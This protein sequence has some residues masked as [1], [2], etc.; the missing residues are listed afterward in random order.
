MLID[1]RSCSVI[2]REVSTCSRW[3]QIERPMSGQCAE[4]E[5][6][7]TLSPEWD[8]FVKNHTPR[9]DSGNPGEEGPK[10][11]KSQWRWKTP[12]KHDL[13]ITRPMKDMKPQRL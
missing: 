5:R 9:W 2:I 7:Y 4:S 13:N 11:F 10:G 6:S 12:R 1:H 8:V 3:G